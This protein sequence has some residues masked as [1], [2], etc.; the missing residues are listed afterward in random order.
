MPNQRTIY[1]TLDKVEMLVNQARLRAPAIV[2]IGG[3]VE[4]G[5]ELAQ[6]ARAVTS[7]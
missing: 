3:V 4:I 6:L 5:A 2:V 7:G 1:S